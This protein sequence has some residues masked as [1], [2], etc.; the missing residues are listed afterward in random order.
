ML[1][2]NARV[3]DLVIFSDGSQAVIYNIYET[4]SG[5]INIRFDRDVTGWV[6]ERKRR[7]WYYDKDGSFVTARDN[8]THVDIVKVIHND[9]DIR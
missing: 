8:S 3:G 2:D 9:Q 5:K 6:N 7:D 1:L 4:T